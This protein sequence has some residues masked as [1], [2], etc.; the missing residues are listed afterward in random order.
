MTRDDCHALDVKDHLAGLRDQFVISP[1]QIYLDGN[2][3]GMLPRA[4]AARLQHVV[5]TEW[6][7]DLIQS[8]NKAGWF[9]K[10]GD[11]GDKIARLIGAGRGEVV[12]ADSTS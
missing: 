9:I 2:S 10:P 6:G 12:A 3:L 4:T 7:Q 8:W 1:G 11:V 5:A